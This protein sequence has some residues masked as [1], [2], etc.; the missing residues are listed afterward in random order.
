MIHLQIK[1]LI[2]AKAETL[3]VDFVFWSGSD[4]DKGNA[5]YPGSIIRKYQ[6]LIERIGQSIRIG[7]GNFIGDGFF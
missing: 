4:I 1:E 7:N 2:A 6:M 5:K 3:L